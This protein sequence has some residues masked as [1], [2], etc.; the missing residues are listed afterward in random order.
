MKDVVNQCLEFDQYPNLLED[1][2]RVGG[3]LR[4]I[5]ECPGAFSGVT[6]SGRVRR[7]VSES[8]ARGVVCN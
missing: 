3:Q 4:G 7:K 2:D 5:K 8:D 1:A 6:N